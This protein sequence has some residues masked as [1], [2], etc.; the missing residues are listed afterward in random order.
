[1]IIKKTIFLCIISALISTALAGD[2]ERE[3]KARQAFMQVLAYNNG[4]LA[5]MARGKMP[6]D[7]ELAQTAAMNLKLASQMNMGS[8][9][10][11]G[12]DMAVAGNDTK[13]KAELWSTWPQVG[14]YLGD[15]G[16]ASVALDA[17]AGMG[18]DQMKAALTDVGKACS[19]CH[20][21]FRAK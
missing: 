11:A 5:G 18:L 17:A 16:K 3:I 4:L 10:A 1:M 6:Y 7:A 20:K 2:F 14:T 12:S 21:K 15:L 9:W 13:A 8:V 19:A